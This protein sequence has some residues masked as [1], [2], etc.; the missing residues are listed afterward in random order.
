MRSSLPRYPQRYLA[1]RHLP[2]RPATLQ[3]QEV[4]PSSGPLQVLGLEDPRAPLK[5]R[6]F[7][8]KGS[9]SV[10]VFPTQAGCLHALMATPRSQPPRSPWLPLWMA[11]TTPLA[12]KGNGGS[13][14]SH[15]MCPLSGGSERALGK[16]N[17]QCPQAHG[18]NVHSLSYHR[19][20]E[21][22]SFLMCLSFLDGAGGGR[23]HLGWPGLGTRNHRDL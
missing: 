3:D 13:M 12:L 22:C 9:S 4:T 23:S 10:K 11:V 7:N 21:P 18:L 16:P 8:D 1:A 5:A 2:L 14:V 19:P 17:G 20:E 15:I 6:A